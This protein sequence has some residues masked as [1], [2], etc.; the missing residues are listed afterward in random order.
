MAARAG[1]SLGEARWLALHAQGLGRTRPSARCGRAALRSMLQSV[2]TLQLDAIRVVDYTQFLVPWSRLGAYDR[3]ALHA[4]GGPGGD[5]FEYWGHAASLQP[6]DA[7]PLFRWRMQRFV[8]GS[9]YGPAAAARVEAWRQSHADYIAAVHA[10]VAERGPLSAGQL[11]DPRRNTGTWWARRS[12]GR[13]ALEWLF[14]R[15]ELAAW[16]TPSFERV[17]DLPERVIPVEILARPTPSLEDAQRQLLVRS[18]RALGVATLPDLADY[19]R[20]RVPEARPRVAE[21]VEAGELVPV[22]V[23]GWRE[24]AYTPAGA[25]PRAPTREHASLLS[26]FDSLVWERSRA[27]RLFG[28]DYRI[29]VYTPEAARRYGYYVLPLLLGDALV[30]RLD[31]RNDRAASALCVPGAYLESG[32][33]AGRVAEAAAHELRAL[34]SWIGLERVAVGRRGNLAGAL[35]A[36]LSP[37]RRASAPAT[38]RRPGSSAGR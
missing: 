4:M 25:R 20:L 1:L 19:F 5:L 36:A 24:R 26:P 38:R 33:D 21:L 35:R 18:A 14:G 7:Q 11:R 13:E 10:E 2:G 37:T 30:A 27:Q 16:R 23:E 6:V 3:D 34:A 12:T 9:S 8:N 15:G 29:E 32:H 22:S 17:Y 28:F 31:V